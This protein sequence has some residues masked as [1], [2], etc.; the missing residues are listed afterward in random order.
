MIARVDLNLD[1][2]ELPDEPD[3]LYGL[4]TVANIA[5]GGHAGDAASMAR[6]ISFTVARG[7]RIAAHPSYPDRAGFGR[8]RVEIDAADLAASVEAQCGALQSIARKLGFSAG[9]VKPHGA[10]YHDAASDPRVAAAVALGATR[11]LGV[12]GIVVVGPPHGALKAEAQRRGLR[13][14]REGFADRAYTEEGALVPRSSP[15]ALITDRDA[16][17]RQAIALAASGTVET[18]CLHS[19]TPG[20]VELAV[21]VREALIHHGYLEGRD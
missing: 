9:I 17:V 7:A 19:D 5:C 14:A 10:L 18:I 6:A 15:G 1:L 20:A 16:A 4:L 3:A 13:Y 11:G 12:A 8:A 2:G 21:A